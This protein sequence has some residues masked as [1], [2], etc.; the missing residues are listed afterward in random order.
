[1]RA[2]RR[3]QT[4]S[5]MVLAAVAVGTALLWLKPVLIPLGLAVFVYLTLTPLV[6]RMVLR[7]GWPRFLAAVLSLLP[8]LGLLFVTGAVTA[9][10]LR[11]LTRNATLY[12]NNLRSLLERIAVEFPLL[13]PLLDREN[14][15][16]RFSQI[17]FTDL[18]LGTTNA[19]F[20]MLATFT[21]VTIF[22]LFL[23]LGHHPREPSPGT[24]RFIIDTR[25]RRYLVVKFAVSLVTAV[26]VA[27]ILS[28]LDVELPV[29]FGMLTFGLNFIPSI[30][31]IIATLIPLPMVLVSP[32]VTMA[33]VLMVLAIP[34]TIQFAIGNILE[35]KL[36]GDSLDLHPVTVLTALVFWGAL[37]G[38]PGMLMAAPI[39]AVLKMVLEES[40]LTQPVA[41]LMAGRRRP[42][43]PPPPPPP[44]P[45]ELPPPEPSEPQ[46]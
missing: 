4:I 7:W 15:Q 5:L 41:R 40:E 29:V 35:P 36:L 18:L 46:Q 2:E 12:Q 32:D 31:S 8:A 11:R 26:I 19:F 10:A 39:T 9:V 17:E 22:V 25:I 33:R 44:V 28:A 37:W 3:L 45:A 14:L 38:G 20:G 16:E 42:T 24:L 27:S 34:G 6:D 1:M 13:Q 30:G 21:L 43:V 23:M